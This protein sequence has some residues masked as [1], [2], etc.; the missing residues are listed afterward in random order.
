[1]RGQLHRGDHTGSVSALWDGRYRRTE[2]QITER[3][4]APEQVQAA[5][6]T[7]GFRVLGIYHADTEEPL[8]SDSE[9]MV[10]VARK[11]A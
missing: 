6:E 3:A 1:M 2:E 7:I 5:L 4:Y 11:E 8:H 9:R 10:V